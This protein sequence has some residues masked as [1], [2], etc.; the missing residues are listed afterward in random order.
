MAHLRRLPGYKRH[1]QRI[2]ESMIR[3]GLS[4]G[5]E[6]TGVRKVPL[7]SAWLF[8]DECGRKLPIDS[9]V[10]RCPSCAG[11][12]QIGYDYSNARKTVSRTLLQ[13]RSKFSMWRYQE[14]LPVTSDN[15]V[16]LGEGFTPLVQADRLGE[17]LGLGQLFLKLEY[18]CPTGSFKDRGSSLLLSKAKEVKANTV[19][20]DS[21]GNAAAS[22]AAYSAKAGIPCY[23]FA[24]SYA[25]IGKLTQAIA[26]EAKVV[27]VEGTR[28]DTF[29]AAKMAIA[30]YGWYYCAFQVNPFASEGSKTIGYEVCEQTGWQ[31]PDY[32]VFP[33]GTGS[34]L[35]GCWKGLKESRELGL[36]E[37]L[38]SMVC[39]QPEG[40]SPIA[41]AFKQGK[42]IVPFEKAQ[43]IAEGL[44]ISQ[45]LKGKHVLSALTESHGQAETVSDEEILSA[46]KL[47]AKL[48]GVFVEPS[49][50]AAIAGLIKLVNS[51]KIDRDQKIA[52]ILTGSGLKT[53][54]TYSGA[55]PEPLTIRPT[56]NEIDKI[57]TK[58]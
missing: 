35:M 17:S 32:L 48:E 54:E 1:E 43:T 36:V 7:Q 26:N 19:A 10:Y 58:S 40:C 27:K 41:R 38:P 56:Q 4:Y 34:G 3:L 53:L 13:S 44:M 39:V 49:S 9:N 21:S 51:G 57:A 47:L 23:V 42:E 45:P 31:P 50:A 22:L 24:P 8:C 14:L 55:F 11:M 12:L 5:D 37:K 6:I 18:T 2:M 28:K 16:S 33:V 25:S 29:E 20:I 30:K 46:A 15:V 52:C